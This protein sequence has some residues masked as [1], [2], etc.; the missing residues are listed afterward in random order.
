MR[1]AILLAGLLVA[2]PVMAEPAASVQVSVHPGFGRIVFEFQQL[3]GFS[4]ERLDDLAIVHFDGG[5]MVPGSDHVTR[6][7]TAV[8]GGEDQ[9]QIELTAGSRLRSVR[10]GSRVIVDVLDP[11]RAAPVR[12]P[13]VLAASHPHLDVVPGQAP[14][15][16]GSPV[17][18]PAIIRTPADAPAQL[19]PPPEQATKLPSPAMAPATPVLDSP[20]EPA[21]LAATPVK[22]PAGVAGSAALLPFEA[23]VG[24]AA[25]RRDGV[26]WI[27]FDGRRPIDLAALHDD[28][29]LGGA[30]VQLLTAATF[31]RLPLA[32]G[33]ELR[34]T[35]QPE[36]WMVAAVP[37]TAT[38]LPIAPVN[39]DGHLLLPLLAPGNVVVVPDPE[40]GQNLL[41]GTL[42]G[43][44]AGVPVPYQSPEFVLQPTWQGVL[45]EPLSDRVSLHAS[46]DGFALE[47]GAGA[48]AF[49]SVALSQA[50]FLTRRF[51]FPAESPAT[52]LRR[53][54]SQVAQAGEAPPLSRAQPRVAAAQSMIALGMG[55]EAQSVLR[56]A[57]EEDPRLT[58]DPDAQGLFAIAALLSGRDDETSGI[59]AASLSGTDEVALWRAVRAARHQEGAPEAAP[60]FAATLPL[61][62]SYPEALQDRLLPLAVET[63]AVGGAAQAADAV[64]SARPNDPRLAYARALRLEAAGET[65]PALAAYDALAQG[66]DRLA[67]TRAA[68]RATLLR[69]T[70]GI[71]TSSVAA[72][73]LESQF[74]GWRGDDRERDLRLRVAALRAD[75]GAWRPAFDLL[76]ETSVLYPENNDIIN[77]RRT[78]LLAK[79]LT[80]ATV[81]AI[82]A[83]DLVAL[84]EENAE[85]VATAA[86]TEIS[87]LLAD[88]LASLDLPGRA[89][90]VL[91]R[92]MHAAAPGV[93]Q[94]AIGLRL[95]SVRFGAGDGTGAAAALDA[96][97]AADL[98]QLLIEQRVLLGAKITAGR[99]SPGAAAA[100]LAALDSVAADDLRA[101]LLT[102]AHEWR[103][104]ERATQDLADKTVPGSGPIDAA[105]QDT[106][107]RL[108][109]AQQRAG[110]TAALYALGR[111]MAMR[112]TGPRA[113]MFRL[114][115][116]IPVNG[117]SDLPR[118][119]TEIALARSIPSSLAAI[120]SR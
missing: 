96:S 52:L 102:A 9:A 67:S 76:R 84:A 99:G 30:T 57:E 7:V 34:L 55:P 107:L 37:H 75:A 115:T 109:T 53:L 46:P 66:R 105:G 29:L 86:P 4:I 95:A 88:K 72:D 31:L 90:P 17:P 110:D 22:L 114:L 112:M 117:V 45:V 62:L 6:N 5:G 43:A 12:K 89:G 40:T 103:G 83:F 119:S 82:S 101:T 85:L 24:A 92:M 113:D 48:P 59:A 56:L 77:S 42:R 64:L 93:A 65:G 16:V 19:A 68:L 32:V 71:M 11:V 111:Q 36:G 33:L 26:A 23:K 50:A 14:A 15:A 21:V 51:D 60:V 94:A 78:Q 104:A 80:R 63:M 69:L 10:V 38:I 79:L 49:P 70:A 74:L 58:N 3:N 25:F 120:G 2:L 91:E 97:A 27:I 13:P 61:V 106:V 18:E 100:L 44:P 87:G 73:S 35:R 118:A 1:R 81:P 98:P 47:T 116:A 39:Q 108:A 54:Q 41:V 20:V 28:P 8:R